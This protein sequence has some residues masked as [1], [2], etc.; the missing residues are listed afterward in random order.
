VQTLRGSAAPFGTGVQRPIDDG[1]AQLRQA[2][3]HAPSQQTPSTQKL[4]M[5]SLAA[6]HGWPFGLAP[7]LPF[8]SQI[9][10]STQSASLVHLGMQAP[11][12]QRYGAQP[13]TPGVRH[14]PRPLHVPA[15]LRRSP[16]L[17][18]GATQIVSA[19]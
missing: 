7:Q 16:P 8:A 6:A 5:H 13:C 12:R 19:A 17:H 1:S 10:P 18:D 9:W 15:V 14:V 3:P 2:P 4:L 11:S